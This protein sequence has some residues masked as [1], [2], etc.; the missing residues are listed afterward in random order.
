MANEILFT[1]QADWYESGEITD[2]I[3]AIQLN[4][5]KEDRDDNAIV[6]DMSLDGETFA[7]N[8]KITTSEKSICEPIHN[9]VA[10]TIKK[11]KCRNKPESGYYIA[12]E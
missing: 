7:H 2:Q 10:G 11:I 9:D 3:T 5:A 8:I 12:A 1:K 4:F 6:I